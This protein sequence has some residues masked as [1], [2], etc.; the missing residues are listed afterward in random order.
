MTKVRAETSKLESE[1]AGIINKDS[2]TY[3][4]KLIE[5]K[6]SRKQEGVIALNIKKK[7]STLKILAQVAHTAAFFNFKHPQLIEFLVTTVDLS[8][9]IFKR[10][11][12]S[13]IEFFDINDAMQLIIIIESQQSAYLNDIDL[14]QLYHAMM[15][16]RESTK[17]SP[18]DRSFV[19]E[20]FSKRT[21]N[22]LKSIS[23]V[24]LEISKL[25]SEI[26][27]EHSVEQK[28][29]LIPVDFVLTQPDSKDRTI[30]IDFH[31]Y[32]HFFRNT[33][34]LKGGLALKE[35]ILTSLNCKYLQ[36]SI[37]DWMLLDDEGKKNYLR[38]MLKTVNDS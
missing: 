23:M 26:G 19:I 30:A 27:V 21:S 1:L 28:V 7:Y 6:R 34:R 4:E 29:E 36:I 35:K 16:L 33:D 17:I 2:K 10:S 15:Y 37:F 32:S 8:H 3:R 13:F 5:V 31:G 22:T 11:G 9:K 18:S 20:E 12:Q 38:E 25:L 14:D 24:N